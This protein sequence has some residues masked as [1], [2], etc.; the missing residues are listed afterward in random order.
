[1]SEL[2]NAVIESKNKN[3]EMLLYLCEKFK[4]LLKKYSYML[5]YEDAYS[6]L[7]VSFIKCI[8]KMPL[9]NGNFCENDMYILSYIKKAIH[10]SYIQLNAKFEKKENRELYIED[11]NNISDVLYKNSDSYNQS[12][13]IIDI[14]YIL[15]KAE[16]DLFVLKYLYG[17]SNREIS[18]YFK[19]SRRAIDK[20]VKKINEKLR[21]K[22]Y[23]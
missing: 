15:D 14:S 21:L 16:Y 9:T 22:L 2:C 19:I 10:N 1:M 12:L 6:D 11:D 4:P 20:R 17:F 5:G 23:C 3:T 13:F 8:Y 7:L 18:C